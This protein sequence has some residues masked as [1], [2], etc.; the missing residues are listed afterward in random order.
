MLSYWPKAFAETIAF[1]ADGRYCD[2]LQTSVGL[3]KVVTD[4]EPLLGL[5]PVRRR[6]SRRDAGG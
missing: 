2:L 5:Q 3:A 1:V 6:R 4:R